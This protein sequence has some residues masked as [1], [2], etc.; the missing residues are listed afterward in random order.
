[1]NYVVFNG[2]YA[3][4]CLLFKIRLISRKNLQFFVPFVVSFS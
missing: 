3:I 4:H 2:V 1:M